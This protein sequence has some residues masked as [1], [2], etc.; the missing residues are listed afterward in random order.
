MHPESILEQ[1]RLARPAN[2]NDLFVPSWPIQ[3]VM[4][5]TDL[6]DH[7][8][9]SITCALSI[10]RRFHAKLTLLHVWQ[11][12]EPIGP[13]LTL[14][15]SRSVVAIAAK[16]RDAQDSAERSLRSLQGRICSEYPATDYCFLIGDPCE[17]I[18]AAAKDFRVDLLVISSHHHVWLQ[19]IIEKSESDHI[20]R[21]APCPVLVIPESKPE[22]V[23][24]SANQ[25]WFKT[26]G[27]T[28]TPAWVSEKESRKCE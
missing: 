5:P 17:L 24:A 27:A 23:R 3:R 8:E 16:R 7:S 4:V 12:E 26:R 10:A 25:V 20:I 6:T 18:V 19:R 11:D 28:V 22:P 9:E 1:A 2:P 21:D 15:D 13:T 14:L